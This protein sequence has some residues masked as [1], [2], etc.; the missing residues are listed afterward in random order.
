MQLQRNVG[1][2]FPKNISPPAKGGIPLL[3]RIPF[4]LSLSVSQQDMLHRLYTE[5][6]SLMLKAAKS[7]LK[8]D[9]K[10]D[11]ALSESFM[12]VLN[13]LNTIEH[14]APNQVKKYML[15]VAKNVCFNMLKKEKGVD[16]I[17]ELNLSVQS[18]ENDVIGRDGENRVL[19]IVKSLP[20]IYRDA[21]YLSLVLGLSTKETAE[22]LGVSTENVRK[23][24]WRGKR[25]LKEML[26]KE[27]FDYE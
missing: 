27:G 23:R 14:L 17:D 1:T 13:N 7:I 4:G 25:M 24:V 10:A 3:F 22:S 18:V 12:R 19:A 5:Y 2:P 6:A 26:K 15:I 8:D 9:H 11:D 16:N 20:D 21:I